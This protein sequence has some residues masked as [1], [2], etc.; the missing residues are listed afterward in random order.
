MIALFLHL[1]RLFPFLPA[2]FDR[3]RSVLAKDSRRSD[4]RQHLPEWFRA[5]PGSTPYW[6]PELPDQ[7]EATLL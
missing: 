4:A 5:I 3:V 2:A 7:A 6:K 1:L